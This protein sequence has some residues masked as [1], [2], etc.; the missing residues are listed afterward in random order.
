M[1]SFFGEPTVRI[2]LSEEGGFGLKPYG[3]YDVSA[4]EGSVA[5]TPVKDDA[6]MEI[7]GI[8]IGRDFHWE[9]KRTMRYGGII[10]L[11][12]DNNKTIL[13]NLLKAEKYLQSVV[14]SEMNPNAPEEFIKAHAIIARS[15]LLKMMTSKRPNQ[16]FAQKNSNIRWTTA[17]AHKLYDVCPD[18]HCQRYQGLDAITANSIIAVEATRGLILIDNDG[19]IADTRYSKC[20][21]G[22]TELFSTCWESVD[23]PYLTSF[24]DPYCHPS[25]LTAALTIYPHLLK[26]YDAST[27]DYYEWDEEVPTALIEKNLREQ[28]NVD[29]GHIIDLHPLQRG[30]SGRISELEVVGSNGSLVIGKELSIRRLLSKSHLLSSAFTIKPGQDLFILRG[31]GWGHGVGLCQ[32]GAA[33]MAAEGKSFREILGFYFP[34]TILS[35]VYE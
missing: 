12:R 6:F 33:V 21:G 22:K 34:N 23:Y 8:R 14:G 16:Q 20:C 25:R 31:R 27:R 10:R 1:I 4:S 26:D 24:E 5:Y 30:P 3:S 18:D 15:W 19:E 7:S 28:Y 2:G 35:K 32:I 9:S 17:S 13:L 11:Q 29:I